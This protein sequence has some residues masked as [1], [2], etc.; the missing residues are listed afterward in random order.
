MVCQTNESQDLVRLCKWSFSTIQ[1]AYG[2]DTERSAQH[3]EL[4]SW[5]PSVSDNSPSS[6]FIKYNQR[7]V[8]SLAGETYLRFLNES[9]V[10][11]ISSFVGSLH[12]VSERER[13]YTKP[14]GISSVSKKH[15]DQHMQQQQRWQRKNQT[16]IK[17]DTA[18]DQPNLFE[19]AFEPK[20]ERLP[21]LQ[22][23]KLTQTYP[24]RTKKTTRINFCLQ[25]KKKQQ[26]Q[27]RKK[28]QPK[29]PIV[30]IAHEQMSAS[31]RHTHFF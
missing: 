24:K 26:Q 23:A 16:I 27:K 4:A 17:R 25:S 1:R 5:P 18:N 30:L 19:D 15:K 29:T 28:T 6:H 3:N 31:I 11:A 8:C 21:S 20:T 12:E 13:E 9:C 7:I 10:Y 22:E 14:R 2:A